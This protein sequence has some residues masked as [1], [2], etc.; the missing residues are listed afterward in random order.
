MTIWGVSGGPLGVDKALYKLRMKDTF[1]E[2]RRVGA[3]HNVDVLVSSKWLCDNDFCPALVGG[4]LAYADHLS[5]HGSAV[6]SKGI[7]NKII[8]VKASL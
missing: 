1:N 4:I 5:K 6:V 3:R 7:I 8:E 2:I